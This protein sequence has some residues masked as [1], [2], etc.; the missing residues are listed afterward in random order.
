MPPSFS[1][2]H[3]VQFSETDMAGVVHFSNYFRWLEEVEHAFFRSVG[4]SVHNPPQPGDTQISWPRVSAA[5]EYLAPARFEDDVTMT[6]TLTRLGEKSLTYEVDFTIADKPI[7]KAKLTSVC[8]SITPTSFTPIPIPKEI[9][10]K[11]SMSR[12]HRASA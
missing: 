10:E 12:D 1:T 7:A 2:T 9:R 6:L 5:C 11:L 3:S 8:C 4:L